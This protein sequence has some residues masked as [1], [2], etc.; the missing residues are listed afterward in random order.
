MKGDF[1]D[2]GAMSAVSVVLPADRGSLTVTVGDTQY[3]TECRYETDTASQAMSSA[4]IVVSGRIVVGQREGGG[5]KMPDLPNLQLLFSCRP[6]LEALSGR[7]DGKDIDRFVDCNRK[8]ALSV[9]C[10]AG[11]VCL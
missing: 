2:F 8:R 1:K 9:T 7:K 10:C 11:S 4:A 3:I 5:E 6:C